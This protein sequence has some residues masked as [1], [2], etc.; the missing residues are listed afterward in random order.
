MS[1]IFSCLLETYRLLLKVMSTDADKLMSVRKRSLGI[2]LVHKLIFTEYFQHK[3]NFS[4]F[5]REDLVFL[6]QCFCFGRS[7]ISLLPTVPTEFYERVNFFVKMPEA[8]PEIQVF[9]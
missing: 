2:N 5:V 3:L 8:F 4:Y 9:F 7:V 1:N 6:Q